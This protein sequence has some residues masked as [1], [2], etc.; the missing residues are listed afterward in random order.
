LKE[1]GIYFLLFQTVKIF[2]YVFS[3]FFFIAL[4]FFLYRPPQVFSIAHGFNRGNLYYF[5]RLKPLAMVLTSI[6]NYNP[7]VETVGYGFLV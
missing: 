3:F 4:R 1:C 7:T 2:D 5:Q 6:P